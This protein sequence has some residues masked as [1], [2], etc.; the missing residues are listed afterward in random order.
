MP[1]GSAWASEGLPQ[2]KQVDT[3]ASQI[4]WMAVTFALLY[5]ILSRAVLPR[6]TEVMEGRQDKI[7]DDLARAEKLRAEADDV[8]AEYEKAL[9]DARAKASATLK[10]ATDEVN[11]EAAKRQEAFAK[12]LGEKTKAAESRIAEARAQA[13]SNLTT[14]AGDAAAAVTEKL[15]GV[16]PKADSV[17][18]AVQESVGGAH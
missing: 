1:V 5:F 18:K 9:A 16:S 10:K 14:V 6:F 13:M 8:S 7:D 17:D 15:I 4:F 2:I 3:F 11:D 12:E